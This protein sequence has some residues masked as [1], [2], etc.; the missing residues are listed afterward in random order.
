MHRE[1]KEQSKKRKLFQWMYLLVLVSGFCVFLLYIYG[2]FQTATMQTLT[3]FNSDFVEQVETVS[4][5]MSNHIKTS[6]MQMFYTSSIKALRT[7]GALT[8]AEKVTG[9]R[10]LGNFVGSSESLESVMVYNSKLDM[11]FTSESVYPSASGS[12]FHDSN[13]VEILKSPEDYPYLVPIKRSI[14]NRITYSFLFFEYKGRDKSTLLLNI[15]DEWYQTQ[16]LGMSKTEDSVIVGA[17]G[18]ILAVHNLAIA[19]QILADW[20]KIFSEIERNPEEGF[21]LP[22]FLNSDP[23]WMY[24]RMKLADGYY[25]KPLYLKE[26]APGLIHIRNFIFSTVVVA[27]GAIILLFGYLLIKIYLPFHDIRQLLRQSGGDEKNVSTH[28]ETLMEGQRESTLKQQLANL[29]S[30]EIPV[31][32][33]FPLQLMM[34]EGDGIEIFKN[35][36]P[37]VC[38]VVLAAENDIGAWLLISACSPEQEKQMC[39]LFMEKS[40][41]KLFMSSICLTSEEMARGYSAIEELY[42]LRFLYPEQQIMHQEIIEKCNRVSVFNAKQAASI[43]NAIKAEQQNT[44]QE[45]WMQI[46]SLIRK[47]RYADFRFTIRYIN[48]QLRKLLTDMGAETVT[49]TDTILDEMKD[50]KDLHDY[51]YHQFQLAVDAVGKKKQEQ[52]MVLSGQI[53]EFI[54]QHYLDP[55]FSAQHVASEFQMNA[56]YLSRQYHQVTQLSISDAIHRERILKACQLLAQ[57]E[58]PVEVVAR[59]AGYGNNEKYFYV[60]FKKWTGYTPGAYRNREI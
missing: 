26:A 31:G 36:L 38:H 53:D 34:T 27:G 60:L 7:K 33:L 15:T 22:S 48:K 54:E 18:E 42:A 13:A 29:R 37:E 56:A 43:I 24:C 59:E 32:V 1:K 20:N 49:V 39:Q 46:F 17:D 9:L 14:E 44:A 11:V 4:V 45:H 28:I 25:I 52:R 3:T 51:M 21:V 57:T 8:N 23:G 40:K 2:Q 41:K 16:L 6:A 35:V 30:G 47:D 5:F 12:E 50:I 10:D 19:D 55:L 58:K